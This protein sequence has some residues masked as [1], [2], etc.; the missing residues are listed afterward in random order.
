MKG[1]LVTLFGSLAWGLLC[2]L[3]S[4]DRTSATIL[5]MIGGMMFG[6]IGADINK[7]TGK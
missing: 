1:F 6:F 2:G 7:R 4:A 5:A 3:L